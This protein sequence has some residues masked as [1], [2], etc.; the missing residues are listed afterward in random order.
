M[1]GGDVKLMATCGLLLGWKVILVSFVIGCLLGSIIHSIR[2]AIE[3][4]DKLLALGPYL[5]MG[6]YVGMLFGPTIIDFYLS[7]YSS[8]SVA[9]SSS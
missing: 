9:I 3:G 6:V 1:G 2:M 8:V 5:A 7:L 4:K